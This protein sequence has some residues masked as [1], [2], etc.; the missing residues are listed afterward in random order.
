MEETF[1]SLFCSDWKETTQKSSFQKIF[2]QN[3]V[4]EQQNVKWIK[5]IFPRPPGTY[6]LSGHSG[7]S[8]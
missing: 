8:L 6:V 5:Y 1:K 3:F 7:Q 4:F 2:S